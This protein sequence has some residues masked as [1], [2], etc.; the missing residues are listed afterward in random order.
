MVKNSTEKLVLGKILDSIDEIYNSKQ[1][2]LCLN[3][4]PNKL[5]QLSIQ[6]S[7]DYIIQKIMSLKSKIK[8]IESLDKYTI[9]VVP[10]TKTN[11]MF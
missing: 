2:R 6:I 3:L 8:K 9:S 7:T 1:C 5:K 4:S 11:V 10:Q